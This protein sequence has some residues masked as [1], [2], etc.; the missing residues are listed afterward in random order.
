M[1]STLDSL[2]SSL[3]I[4][5][6]IILVFIDLEEIKFIFKLTLSLHF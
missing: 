6:L 1:I 3:K 4:T 2:V 5:K